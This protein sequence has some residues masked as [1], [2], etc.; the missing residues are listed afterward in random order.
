MGSKLT[1]RI[2]GKVHGVKVNKRPKPEFCELCC[3]E[4]SPE[5]QNRLSWHHWDRRTGDK[6]LWLCFRCHRLAEY[7][8]GNF[9]D[10]DRLLKYRDKYLELKREQDKLSFLH[11]LKYDLGVLE[12]A[13]RLLKNSDHNFIDLHAG[14]KYVSREL[15]LDF[16]VL[17]SSLSELSPQVRRDIWEK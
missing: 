12:E 3:D 4:G 16:D 6:G 13:L 2:N 5:L 10:Q 11:N 8:D 1:I 7:L 17:V 15:G 9:N 14:L